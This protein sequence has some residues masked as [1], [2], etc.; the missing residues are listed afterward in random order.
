MYLGIC[1]SSHVSGGA[2]SVSCKRRTGFVPNGR[3]NVCV[4][5]AKWSGYIWPGVSDRIVA[6][7]LKLHASPD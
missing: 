2:R 1:E 6:K 3:R 5:N 4:A 7:F